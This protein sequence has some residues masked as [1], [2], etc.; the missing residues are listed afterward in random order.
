MKTIRYEFGLLMLQNP[1]CP[2][3]RAMLVLLPLGQQAD[4][5]SPVSTGPCIEIGTFPF[6]A[7]SHPQSNSAVG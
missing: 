4:V 7:S 2:V 5:T 1:R 6:H 3:Y